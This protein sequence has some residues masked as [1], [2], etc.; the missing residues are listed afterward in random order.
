[1]GA[2]GR[3]ENYRMTTSGHQVRSEFV[4]ERDPQGVWLNQRTCGVGAASLIL[5]KTA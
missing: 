3:G 4:V 2:R 5:G 1:M